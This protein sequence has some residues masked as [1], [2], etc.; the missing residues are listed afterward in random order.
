MPETQVSFV[1]EA[2]GSDCPF[3]KQQPA[4]TTVKFLN[5]KTNLIFS[6]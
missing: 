3:Q 1:N 5:K 6:S 2:P 4:V